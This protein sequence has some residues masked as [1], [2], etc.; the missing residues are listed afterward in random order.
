MCNYRQ[1]LN[2]NAIGL[3]KLKHLKALFM[4]VLSDLGRLKE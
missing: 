1:N 4:D 2:L 3:T